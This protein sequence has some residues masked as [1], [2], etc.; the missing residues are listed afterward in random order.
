MDQIQKI[1]KTIS[2][3]DS[4]KKN[5]TYTSS[6]TLAT[7]TS[8]HLF[9]KTLFTVRINH[10]KTQSQGNNCIYQSLKIFGHDNNMS[11]YG[12][13]HCI[14][15]VK[16]ILIRLRIIP[17]FTGYNKMTAMLNTA[18]L[19]IEYHFSISYCTRPIISFH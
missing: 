2:A 16:F 11:P 8:F 9:P 4:P 7:S 15:V 19:L 12:L 6:F 1:L 13:V 10:H 14:I 17:E 3:V 5:P 18:W